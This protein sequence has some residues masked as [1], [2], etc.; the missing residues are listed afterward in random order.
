[1]DV[2]SLW[3]LE[4][5]FGRREQGHGARRETLCE[6]KGRRAVCVLVHLACRQAHSAVNFRDGEGPPQAP[7]TLYVA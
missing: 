6:E 7:L 4:I 2:A 5:E 1:M 3:L